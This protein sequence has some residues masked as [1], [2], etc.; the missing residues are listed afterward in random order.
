MHH[1]KDPTLTL[2]IDAYIS[3]SADSA[4]TNTHIHKHTSIEGWVWA[5][6][7]LPHLKPKRK[8]ACPTEDRENRERKNPSKPAGTGLC[9]DKGQNKTGLDIILQLIDIKYD[10]NVF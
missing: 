1:K 2:Y 10:L 7:L 5:R 3:L 8:K 6:P 9:S 4:E